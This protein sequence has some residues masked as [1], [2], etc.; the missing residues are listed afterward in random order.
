MSLE[1]SFGNID[2][3]TSLSST[4]GQPDD[5]VLLS[6]SSLDHLLLVRPQRHLHLYTTAGRSVVKTR[7]EFD[8]KVETKHRQAPLLNN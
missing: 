5:A 1:M 4:C 7:G 3:S 8:R 6:Q 2:S